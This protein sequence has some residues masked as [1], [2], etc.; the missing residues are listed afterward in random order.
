MTFKITNKLKINNNNFKFNDN[1][2]SY[3]TI[4]KTKKTHNIFIY[5]IITLV[6]KNK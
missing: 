5:L 2:K 6:K 4:K 1:F 3:I